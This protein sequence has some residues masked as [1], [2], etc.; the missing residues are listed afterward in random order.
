M[1]EPLAT[2]K[3]VSSLLF[4]HRGQLS[5]RDVKMASL[6]KQCSRSTG[7]TGR[8]EANADQPYAA[9]P[10]PMIDAMLTN[11]RSCK[12]RI[13][14]SDEAFQA[15]VKVVRKVK[16]ACANG[17]PCATSPGSDITRPSGLIPVMLPGTRHA[18]GQF[19]SCLP[20]K[21]K[22]LPPRIAPHAPVSALILYRN[23]PWSA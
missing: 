11:W 21:M 22:A 8:M 6:I 14:K 15:A 4:G 3:N 1:A 18:A 20:I 16:P 9:R 13:P 17:G 5:L 19:A 2:R 10:Q 7:A 12:K 23:Q